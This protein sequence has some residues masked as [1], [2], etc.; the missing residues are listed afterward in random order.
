MASRGGEDSTLSVQRA[1]VVH[2]GA[3]GASGRRWFRGRVEHLSSGESMRF[4]SLRELL[5]FFASAVDRAAADPR[6]GVA[7]VR[8]RLAAAQPRQDAGSPDARGSESSM[9]AGVGPA[10]G[11]SDED[12]PGLPDSEHRD[13]MMRSL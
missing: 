4:T 8:P 12:L 9:T 13:A 2:L 5:A 7:S 6:R 1:F 11:G 3:G 10:H